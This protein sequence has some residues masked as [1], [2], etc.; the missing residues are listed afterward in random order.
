MQSSF[1][2][3]ESERLRLIPLTYEQLCLYSERPE[4]LAENL[5]LK[6]C[7][8]ETE[9]P[10][11][12]GFIEASE[13]VWK[14]KTKENPGHYQWVTN[15]LIVLKETNET[16]G[17]IGFSGLPNEHGETETGYAMDLKHRNKGYMSEALGCLCQWAL[18]QPNMKAI[19]AHTLPDGII[20]QKTLINNG[21]VLV[22]PTTTDDGDV[23][24]WRK[25]K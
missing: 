25:Q 16:V 7:L 19:I 17:G 5:H 11:K 21:F 8:I 12:S 6:N 13:S 23:L 15:W 24:L 3:I 14:P 4:Q 2:Y 22:G 18:Q 10:F 1:F 20:S 9:E